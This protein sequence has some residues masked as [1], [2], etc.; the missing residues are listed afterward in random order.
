M[1]I[2]MKVLA[3]I[4]LLVLAMAIDAI[5]Q[6]TSGKVEVGFVVGVVI[7]ALLILGLLK[8][9]EGV[10]MLLKAFA[11]AGL[12]LGGLGLFLLVTTPYGVHALAVVATLIGVASNGFVIFALND[13]AVQAWMFSRSVDGAD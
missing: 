8:G 13:A 12:C 10:R 11:W 6:A 5:A 7:R 1:K 4:A 9:N 3:V 2:P